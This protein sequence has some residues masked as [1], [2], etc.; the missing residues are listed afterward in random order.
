MSVGR[1]LLSAALSLSIASVSTPALAMAPAPEPAADTG[2][3][4]VGLLRI[5]GDKDTGDGLRS[6]IQSEFESAGFT[7]KGVATDLETAAQKAKCRQINDECLGKIATW[8]GK[9]K[10]VPYDYLVFG[11]AEPADSGK[12][13]K[14]VVYDLKTKAKVKELEGLLT[15]DDFILS[16]VLARAAIEAIND[17]KSPPPPITAEEQKVLDEL[18]EGPGKTPEELRAEAEELAKRIGDVDSMPIDTLPTDKIP[19]DLVK[20]F[21]PFCSDEKRTR[22]KDDSERLDLHPY[23]KRGTFFGYWQTRAW[24][25]LGLTATG[26]LATGVLY[27]AG[28]ALRSPYKK[29]VKS[30]EDSGLSNTDPLQSTEYTN[31]ASDAVAKGRKMRSALIGGDIALGATVLLAGVLAVIIYQDRTAAKRWLREEKG[32]KAVSKLKI[33]DL[34]VAPM[35]GATVQGAGLGFRF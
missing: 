33:Y 19:V 31:L 34:Q 14:L 29:A 6:Y 3:K 12:T 17:A 18:D 24:V 8:L 30:L 20:D 10:A 13:S 32:L 26:L 5:S 11:N 28:L 35:I 2:G 16:I 25:A 21:K 22:R 7:V 23:C 27:G 1:G 9:G 15:S 4:T